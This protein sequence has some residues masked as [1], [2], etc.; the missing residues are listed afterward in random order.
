[1]SSDHMSVRLHLRGLR[2]LE[3]SVDTPTRLEVVV[4]SSA[5]R[6]RCAHCGFWCRRVHDRREKRIRDLS[7]SGRC[8]TLRW[9]RRRFVWVVCGERHL[10]T[11]R[12]FDGKL[13]R[14]LAR[15]LVVD[16][17]QMSLRAVARTHGVGWG[18]IMGHVGVWAS[19]IGD[20]RRS[21]RCGV[22]LVDETSMRRRHRYVT[23]IVNGEGGQVLDML[24]GRS[25]ASGSRFFAA[26]GAR[27][28]AGVRVVVSDGSKPY[29]AA[30]DRHLG[31]ATHVLDRFGVIGW[32]AAGLTA[33]RRD[34]QRRQPA[35]LTPAFDPDVFRARF[36]L[37]R[38]PD[39]L[40]D[41]QR[42][43][44]EAI[45]EA[46]RG[47]ATPGTPSASCTACTSPTTRPAPSPSSTD[48]PIST[49]PATCPSSTRSSTRCSPTCRR[50]SPG[51]PPDSPATAASK[52]PTTSSKSYAAPPTA[53]PTP[54]TSPPAHSS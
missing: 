12:E 9:R 42:A 23:V 33:V 41:A 22:L 10:E 49:R 14:R 47:C 8:V 6:V 20:R 53:S 54:T 5:W 39:R 29:R 24:P 50:S 44:L 2:V 25:E 35:G 18:L 17:Q 19:L 15:R 31:H 37:L 16:A 7:G 48:S 21:Q 32:F 1:M 27:W 52:A 26:G 38:R 28:C 34:V 46:T 13:T 3:V 43:Q 11:H 40:D 51:T 4:E 36:L 45:F 30:I